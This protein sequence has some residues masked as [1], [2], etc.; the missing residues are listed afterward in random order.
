MDHVD[1][2]HEETFV[3]ALLSTDEENQFRVGFARSADGQVLGQGEGQRFLAEDMFASLES[4]DRDLGVPVVW[5]DNAD[6]F[7]VLV[8]EY[9]AIVFDAFCFAF[10]D[11]FVVSSSLAMVRIHIANRDD[12]PEAIVVMGITGSHAS[13][14]DASDFHPVLKRSSDRFVRP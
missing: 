2:S 4:F 9:L 14:T 6:D 12:I 7:D 5:S 3:G 13:H 1:S 8:I 11:T 10:S